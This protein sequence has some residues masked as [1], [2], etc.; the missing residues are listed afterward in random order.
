MNFLIILNLAEGLRL[1]IENKSVNLQERK[2]EEWH[3]VPRDYGQVRYFSDE[4]RMRV[5]KIT[6]NWV[7]EEFGFTSHILET[8]AAGWLPKEM[9]FNVK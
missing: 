4:R 3:T 2:G 7:M 5:D 9:E 8:A 6:R 1:V